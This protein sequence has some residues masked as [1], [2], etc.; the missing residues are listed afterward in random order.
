MSEMIYGF[1]HG[2]DPRQFRPDIEC[3]DQR[4]IDNHAAACKLW[5][6]AEAR[7]EKP[8][9][10]T[11]QSGWT[12]DADGKPIM[13][14]LK[15]PYGIGTYYVDDEA[16]E[17]CPYAYCERCHIEEGERGDDGVYMCTHCLEMMTTHKGA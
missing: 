10:E 14:V 11:C 6:E 1:F 9:P 13:H 17:D 3:C 8:T 5:N 2:G 16:D 7:G 15:S 12:Y 4:E